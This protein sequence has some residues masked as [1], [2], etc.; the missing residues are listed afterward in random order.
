MLPT[1]IVGIAGPAGPA[2]GVDEQ[3]ESKHAP[4]VSIVQP[5]VIRG[6]AST[7]GGTNAA[8]NVDVVFAE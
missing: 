3:Y 6:P 8:M 1:S 5:G 4:I 7:T 2:S